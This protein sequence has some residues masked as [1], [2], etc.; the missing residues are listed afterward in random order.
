MHRHVL[1]SRVKTTVRKSNSSV[2]TW[3]L[4]DRVDVLMEGAEK[5]Q[6]N[7]IDRV[8]ITRVERSRRTLAGSERSNAAMRWRRMSW[9]RP[10]FEA[11]GAVFDAEQH[12]EF[13][14]NP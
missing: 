1:E 11:N 14:R 12:P 10:T 4:Q 7:A 2:G 9:R 3:V 5:T 13:S 6:Q 8:A